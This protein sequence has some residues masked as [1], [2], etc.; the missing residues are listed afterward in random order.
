[1]RIRNNPTIVRF[2]I[3]GDYLSEGRESYF[4]LK[5]CTNTFTAFLSDGITSLIK[6]IIIKLPSNSNQILEEID[7]Y[8]T[9]VYDE[10]KQ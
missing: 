8:N 7:N 3:S 2:S 5:L 6:K 4:P 1:M 9:L 10:I